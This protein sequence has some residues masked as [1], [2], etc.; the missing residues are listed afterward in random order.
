MSMNKQQKSA[1]GQNKNA[2][3][4]QTKKKRKMPKHS[5]FLLFALLVAMIPFIWVAYLLIQA[6]MQTGEPINGH[7]YLDDLNPPI[8]ESHITQVETRLR[9]VEGVEN[10]SV[11][12]KGSTLRVVTD[13]Q[14]DMSVD[15]AKKLGNLL[16]D[17]VF[18]VIDVK[19][20]FTRSG[21]KKMYDLEIYLV[22]QFATK[23][24]VPTL[25]V[26]VHKSSSMEV[27]TTDVLSEPRNKEYVESL[28]DKETQEGE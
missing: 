11:S 4:T 26:L 19:T 23:D 5:K 14:N 27:S 12:L 21:V 17:E 18:G 25:N 20:Y 13:V 28:K 7:R 3:S 16:R 22:D 1:P 8:V 6:S 24:V 15:N 10:V 9:G 2:G